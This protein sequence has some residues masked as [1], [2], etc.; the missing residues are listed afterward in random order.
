MARLTTFRTLGVQA[1]ITDT[2][3]DVFETE[4]VI[5]PLTVSMEKWDDTIVRPP[6]GSLNLEAGNAN[7]RRTHH[8]R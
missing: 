5:V 7:H 1:K 2:G 6:Q 3:G 8:H 4:K